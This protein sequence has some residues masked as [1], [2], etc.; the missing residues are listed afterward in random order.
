MSSQDLSDHSSGYDQGDGIWETRAKG[1]TF[2]DHGIQLEWADRTICYR[3]SAFNTL[4]TSRPHSC[5]PHKVLH[6]HKF[7]RLSLR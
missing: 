4:P 2:H 3:V 5:I 1:G 6:Q 7:S